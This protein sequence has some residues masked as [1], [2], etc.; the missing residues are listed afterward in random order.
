MISISRLPSR[1]AGLASAL[2]FSGQALA[3]GLGASSGQ[4]VLGQ[5]LRVRIALIGADGGPLDASCF[6]LA[7][8]QAPMDVDYVLRDGRLQVESVRGQTQLL[9]SS[10]AAW[11]QPVVE[12][13]V[14]AQCGGAEIAR[15]YLLLASLPA[16]PQPA[17][18][19]TPPEAGRDA[20]RE[21]AR[22]QPR[23]PAA[24]TGMSPADD[25]LRIAADT[26]L[27]ALARGLY[28]S[29]RETRDE[30]RRLIAA[31][32]PALFA[33]RSSVGSVPLP[34]G[35]VLVVPPNL[36]RPEAATRKEAGEAKPAAS[37]QPPR[38]STAEKADKADKRNKPAE[39]AQAGG[40]ADGASGAAASR[41]APDRLVIGGAGG[42]AVKPL[43][44]RE[45][46][47]TL[48]R[49]ERMVEDQGRIHL[50]MSES[51]KTVELAF[52]E[53]RAGLAAMEARTKA[54]EVERIKAETERTKTLARLAELERSRLG[55]LELLAL[56]LAS[57]GIG[58]GLIYFYH[59]LQG[60][61][62][63]GRAQ[64]TFG[65]FATA[66]AAPAP[67]ASVPTPGPIPTPAA[68]PFDSLVTGGP[69]AAEP[70]PARPA[71]APA[72]TL[73]PAFPAAPATPVPPS[74]PAAPAAVDAALPPVAMVM[75]T[76]TA[77]IDPPSPAREV[78][79]TP[80][81]EL[82]PVIEFTFEAPPDVASPT[83]AAPQAMPPRAVPPAAGPAPTAARAG[84]KPAAAPAAVT[85]VSSDPTLELAHLMESMG[86]AQG[87]AQAL[88]E[89]IR[90]NPAES[91]QHWL[92][93]LDIY[94]A[95]GLQDELADSV[96]ELKG[97]F[98]VALDDW[99]GEGA[100]RRSLIDYPHLA[101]ELTAIWGKEGCAAF[102][103]NLIADTRDGTRAGFPRAVVEE[104][105]L[106][107][108]M[109]DSMAA[110]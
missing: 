22:E 85:V 102:L 62:G 90:N 58:A 98:N 18:R 75:A 24:A 87:A 50:G 31:A 48:D 39:A 17:A 104:I 28:P 53:L 26:N 34:A 107:R 92:K 69:V 101:R 25:T 51:M 59:R 79:E 110:G 100:Q 21:A 108:A 106:L 13:R 35:T 68:T 81:P 88:V 86:L 46:A 4:A 84:A 3:I 19:T 95:S 74:V 5:P 42:G 109:L 41:Q 67:A 52:G 105:V 96:K 10:Q 63:G 12:F 99:S 60:R 78:P 7:A 97:K 20:A 33:G 9:V 1:L 27:N 30:Y 14:V 6:R 66:P 91:V 45:L 44:P 73:P 83:A 82:P 38:S 70:P 94:H 2:I 37:S 89:H 55:I 43:S 16:V 40:G 61:A 32:N 23:E 65:D 77:T 57:G 47:A 8:P 54:L 11:R 64:F 49:L 80:R 76:K 93:F 72:A 103:V 71:M 36:P 29:Q 15:D 56:V